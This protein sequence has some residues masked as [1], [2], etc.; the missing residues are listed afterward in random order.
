MSGVPH[1]PVPRPR[2]GP[3][4][5]YV[6]ADQMRGM[7]LGCAGNP[8]VHTP[9]LDRLAAQG[10]RLTHAYA[11]CP[12]CTPSRA[13][14]L[15]G[16]HA[17]ANRVVANDLPLPVELPTL[18]A[19]LQQAGY[20]TGYIGK[21]HLDGVPRGKWTPPGPRRHGFDFWAV[22]NCSHQYFGGTFFGDEP[23]PIVM[24]G[25][26]PVA[27]TDLLLEF[28]EEAATG[29]RATG[30]KDKAR[31][32]NA[33]A[34]NGAQPPFAA[35]LSWG[36]PHD[37][38]DQ[39]PVEHLARYNPETITLRPNAAPIPPGP[40]SLAG[41]R[42]PR[43]TL[44]QYY[45]HITALDEQVGRILD[46]LERLGLADDTIL[47]FTSDHGDMLFSQQR[48]MKQQPWEES[49]HIPFLIRWPG[50]MA[51]GAVLDGLFG[52]V[53]VAPT[54]LGLLDLPPLPGAQGGDYSAWLLGQTPD[55]T[56]DSVFIYD[57]VHVDQNIRQGLPLWRGVRTARHTYARST[58]GPWL[59]YDNAADPYQLENHA[60]DPA[61]SAL[62]AEL[63][64]ALQR[65]LDA[66]GDPFEGDEALL[67][68]LGL[69]ELWNARE[70][71]QH[72]RAPRLL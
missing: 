3:N 43:L 34:G 8:E 30:D 26:E 36:P 39:L 33:E 7:D 22:H 70:R 16:R 15:T 46:A 9:N 57:L 61:W 65:H 20:R 53:D 2:R 56:Q 55:R 35:F 44:C 48:M 45:A 64:R 29:G 62:Q 21:W 60:G 59:L 66:V 11:N 10:A 69:I 27:Q 14:L 32:A 72:P 58:E 13:I 42:D 41:N 25:Y 49:I 24:E 51:A 40:T 17:Q 50:P 37:P 38:Y 23:Q 12:V 71:E 4:L 1:P 47:V 18:G 54:L 28:I 5:I 52:V 68:R 19:A 67:R 31:P 6:F 63:D